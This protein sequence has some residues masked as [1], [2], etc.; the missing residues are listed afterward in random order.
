MAG[1]AVGV[2][3]THT[4][5]PGSRG[6][7]CGA[8][9]AC[10]LAGSKGTVGMLH[11]SY[12]TL[13]HVHDDTLWHVHYDTLW[14]VHYDTLWHV[15]YDTLWHVHYDTL[16]HVHYDTLWHVHYDTLYMRH[17]LAVFNGHLKEERSGISLSDS[18][19]TFPTFYRSRSSKIR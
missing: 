13:W 9:S 8:G 5:L 16:W 7:V 6:G 19:A 10:N 11:A 14:H 12:V 3:V 1:Y 4:A 18:G 15:H 2:T 17:V